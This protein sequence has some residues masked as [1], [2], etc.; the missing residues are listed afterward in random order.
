MFNE[1]G[2][3]SAQKSLEDAKIMLMAFDLQRKKSNK[4]LSDRLEK[5]DQRH[6]E[7][8]KKSGKM[9]SGSNLI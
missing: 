5:L 9:N 4:E 8:V 1:D 3:R 2:L 7:F 6:R